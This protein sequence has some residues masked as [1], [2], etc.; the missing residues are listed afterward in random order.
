MPGVPHEMYDMMHRAVLPDLAARSGERAVIA[1]RVLRTWG[2]SESGLN[3]RLDDVIARLDVPGVPTL[4]F[5]ASGWEGLKVRLTAKADTLDECV[6]QLDEW[7]AVVR[8]EIGHFVFGVDGD[9]MESV[10]L[11]SVPPARGSR[12]PRPNR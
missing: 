12:S 7:E 5:L 11:D 3:E 10:V 6:A 8:A 9:T 4:A 2:E 1:S